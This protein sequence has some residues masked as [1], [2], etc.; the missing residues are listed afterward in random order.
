MA[1]YTVSKHRLETQKTHSFSLNSIENDDSQEHPHKD[2]D[3]PLFDLDFTLPPDY[4]CLLK[5][6]SGRCRDDD[7]E[8]EELRFSFSFSNSINHNRNQSIFPADDLIYK[9]HL[10][11]L[12]VPPSLDMA[13]QH[14]VGDG[15][16]SLHWGNVNGVKSQFPNLLKT[17]TKLKISLLRF[18]KSARV[19]MDLE[20]ECGRSRD[21]NVQRQ[22]K[23]FIV[24]FKMVDLPLFFRFIGD[25]SRGSKTDES[26]N[27]FQRK[28]EVSHQNFGQCKSNERDKKRVKEVVQKYV[29]M[30]K[31]LYLKICQK[32]SEKTKHEPIKKSRVA[33]RTIH[34]GFSGSERIHQKRLSFYDKLK[35]V[36][37]PS[38]KEDNSFSSLN[39][40][41]PKNYSESTVMELQ[42]AIQGAITHCKRSNYTED[43]STS[44]ALEGSPYS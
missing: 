35:M 39:P 42:N 19:G 43:A 33:N 7:K 3:N 40:A 25:N 17:A 31:P 5:N 36:Y 41:V 30:I 22:S 28:S 24:K 15:K 27:W 34:T 38:C 2:D 10:L 11:P 20:G 23:Y 12:Q 14:E 9:G 37:K 26:R 6:N 8:A 1:D 32:Y 4:D 13:R 18:K 44:S 29:K 21:S 16:G